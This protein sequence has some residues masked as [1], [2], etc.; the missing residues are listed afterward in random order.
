[1]LFSCTLK[2]TLTRIGSA[3]GDLGLQN[4]IHVD[5]AVDL[6]LDLFVADFNF[7]VEVNGETP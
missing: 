1:M 2:G 3:A 6:L 7:L 4:K 5:C